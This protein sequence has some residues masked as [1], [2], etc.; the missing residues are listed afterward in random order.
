MQQISSLLDNI[1][2][3]ASGDEAAIE[4]TAEARLFD[5]LNEGQEGVDENPFDELSLEE[6]TKLA[7]DHGIEVDEGVGD[8]EMEKAAFDALGGQV[9]A[10]AAF[11]ELGQIKIAMINGNCRV[12]KENPLDVQGASIC[13]SCLS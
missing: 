1:Y 9:M 2:N 7:Q 10:H 13:S 12:C 11:H 8:V 5:A 6:L 3:E 4:K